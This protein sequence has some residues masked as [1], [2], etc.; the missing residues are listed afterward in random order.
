[1]NGVKV[2]V[3]PILLIGSESGL[4]AAQI[5]SWTLQ[6]DVKTKGDKIV[7][8]LKSMRPT[9]AEIPTKAETP[10][11]SKILFLTFRIYS[12]LIVIS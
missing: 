3:D 11:K 2:T 7:S 5:E 12:R 6:E 8:N 1:M 10:K 4:T 9:K